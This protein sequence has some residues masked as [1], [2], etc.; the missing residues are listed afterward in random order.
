[1]IKSSAPGQRAKPINFMANLS[2]RLHG[3]I[4][5]VSTPLTEDYEVDT[6]SLERLINFLL[7]GGVNGLF[8][9]G[10]TGEM[11]F[12]TD[13]Q[14]A[15]VMEVA[16]KTAA[17]RVPVLAGIL[18]TATVRSIEQGRRALAA[19]VDAL[20]L[21]APF[22]VVTN[23][24]DILEHFRQVH[25]ALDLPIVAY[26]I[27]S[28]VQVKIEQATLLKLAAEGTIIGVKDSSGDTA[29]LR[30]L[31]LARQDIPDFSVFTGTELFVDAVLLMGADGA[32][33]GLANLDPKGFVKL[34][35][36]AQAGNWEMARQ[37]QDRLHRLASIYRVGL[38]SQMHPPTSAWGSIKTSLM[39]RGVI[40]TNVMG[41]PQRRY[42]N[43]EVEQVRAIME[44]VGLAD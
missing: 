42:S 20:V 27:P 41:R 9:L 6:D 35:K 3:I 5:P 32:V 40:K 12:L 33:P 29:N 21:S 2:E 28:A 15:T 13:K 31:L 37:E 14:R 1:L 11:A 26:D 19:G 18:D 16:V 10:S 23:Q 7:D 22:Y 36:A 44:Q 24:L 34:Y 17:G 8:V 38:A 4:P 43:A 39:L 25:A 30:G